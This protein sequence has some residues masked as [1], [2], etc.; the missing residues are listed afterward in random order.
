MLHVIGIDSER[1]NMTIGSLNALKKSEVILGREKHLIMA[2]DIIWEKKIPEH[3]IE[4]K[5]AMI[6]LG[7]SLAT[8]GKEVALIDSND[9][10][11]FGMGNFLFQSL[12]KYNDIDFKIYPCVT[13]INHGASLIGAP[14]TDFATINLNNKL[15]T[16]DEIKEKLESAITSNYVVTIYNPSKKEHFKLIKKILLSLKNPKSP[17]AIVNFNNS[18]NNEITD[19][20]KIIKLEDLNHD[21]I[22]SNTLLIIG[23]RMTYIEKNKLITPEPIIIEPIIHPLT[24]QFYTDFLEDKSP[25][26]ADKSCEYYPC[27]KMKNQLCDF[28]YCPFYPCCDG[29]TGGKWIKNKN[30]WNCIDCSWIHEKKVIDRVKEGINEIISEVD[31]LKMK[32][33]ELM[34]LRRKCIFKTK[35]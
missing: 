19:N 15:I 2:S 20:H 24:R 5:L 32:K 6:E 8:E 34:K 4:D 35:I 21:E 18:N 14:L 28:C 9:P 25:K 12:G 23:N 10:E 30:I 31:D 1:D 17:M 7:I 22:S 33:E 26:G 29:S 27:H 16:L 3:P 13:A 11:V